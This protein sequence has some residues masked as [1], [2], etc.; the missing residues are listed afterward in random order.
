[1]S[2]TFDIFLLMQDK[3][4]ASM[5]EMSIN[6]DNNARLTFLERK[7][8]NAVGKINYQT[9]KLSEAVIDRNGDYVLNSM[10]LKWQIKNIP[11]C[12]CHAKFPGTF[13]DMLDFR[14]AKVHLPDYGIRR[15]YSICANLALLNNIVFS[16][17]LF[18][19]R[20]TFIASKIVF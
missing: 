10:E 12:V 4:N 1:M 17:S 3:N 14:V 15:I 7:S 16:R 18:L 2:Q 9:L 5:H 20:W 19:L 6:F 13:A 8:V 11:T